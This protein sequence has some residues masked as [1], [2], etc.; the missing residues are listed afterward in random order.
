MY[1][2]QVSAALATPS[3]FA[4]PTV[5]HIASSNGDRGPTQTAISKLLATNG[6][7]TFQG[8]SGAS[9][10]VL[11]ATNAIAS[12]YGVWNGTYNGVNVVIKTS[13]L[14]ALGAIAT[15][16]G[17]TTIRYVVGDGTGSATLSDPNLGTTEGTD[18]ELSTADF[19]FSTNFQSTS[20][21]Q[22]CLLYTSDAA[23]D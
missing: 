18:Y 16:A 15:V 22:G 11:G 14:G 1:K 21:F 23:D 8:T 9:S 20:P 12:N 7:W 10:N 19:G 13:Y 4:V 6:A 2:R 17:N 5:I 3:L